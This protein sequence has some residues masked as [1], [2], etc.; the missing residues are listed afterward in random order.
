MKAGGARLSAS[1]RVSLRRSSST[2]DDGKC[3][4]ESRDGES[5]SFRERE[6][7]TRLTS[8]NVPLVSTTSSQFAILR[9][10]HEA[11]RVEKGGNIQTPS[12]AHSHT[13]N[14]SEKLAPRTA[15]S[16]PYFRAIFESLPLL[17]PLP[18][19]YPRRISTSAAV[20]P[21]LRLYPRLISIPA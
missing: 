13:Y 21:L 4:Y 16:R 18:Q 2:S 9:L 6:R 10:I 3:G 14:V 20:V 11:T 1:L 5:P 8:L 7:E 12:A 17:Y 19:L 15:N